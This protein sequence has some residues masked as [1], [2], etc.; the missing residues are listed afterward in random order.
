MCIAWKRLHQ[1]EHTLR[2]SFVSSHMVRPNYSFEA[3]IFTLKSE[4][5]SLR[6]TEA[7]R[8]GK[9]LL[10][11]S[12]EEGTVSLMDVGIPFEEERGKMSNSRV[13]S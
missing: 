6:L 4:I 7:K 13:L 5:W 9:Q 11:V 10:A 1:V 12:S 2:H 8:G 3:A